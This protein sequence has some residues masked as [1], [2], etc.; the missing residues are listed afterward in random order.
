MQSKATPHQHSFNPTTVV[1][2]KD[3]SMKTAAYCT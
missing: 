1:T 2:Y 3:L